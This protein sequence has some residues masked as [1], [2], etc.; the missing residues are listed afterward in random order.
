[1]AFFIFFSKKKS[2][3][4]G[5]KST[6]QGKKSLLQG[7]KPLLQGKNS[8]FERKNSIF[9]RNI[10]FF[11]L[12]KS[13]IFQRINYIAKKNPFSSLKG[14]NPKMISSLSR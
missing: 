12:R 6:F 10:L 2:I 1:M 4:H 7:K 11:I 3:F 14:K 13:P 5:K 8:I 9:C